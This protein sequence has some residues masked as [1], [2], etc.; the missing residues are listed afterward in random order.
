MQAKR[1]MKTPN[2]SLETTV[3]V[4]S[5]PQIFSDSK[6]LEIQ[7]SF[8]T[9]TSPDFLHLVPLSKIGSDLLKPSVPFP[10][11]LLIHLPMSGPVTG[12]LVDEDDIMDLSSDDPL[13]SLCKKCNTSLV[14]H[15][16]LPRLALANGLFVCPRPPGLSTSL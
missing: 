12:L 2:Q 13:L 16:T 14:V 9:N 6:K 4:T 8:L 7:D 10:S 5:W 3:N 1:A 15:S 11:S